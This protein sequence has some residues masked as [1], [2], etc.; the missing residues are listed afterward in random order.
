MPYI[1]SLIPSN[2][3]GRQNAVAANEPVVKDEVF[4]IDY[5]TWHA[6]LEGWNPLQVY[7]ASEPTRLQT[8]KKKVA[9]AA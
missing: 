4:Q 1:T 6:R 3:N 8:G 7:L 9:K 2:R 5:A